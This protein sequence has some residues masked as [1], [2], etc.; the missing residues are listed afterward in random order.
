MLRLMS[1]QLD[2]LR[3][4]NNE[5]IF[6]K[7]NGEKMVMPNLTALLKLYNETSDEA[8]KERAR[9]IFNHEIG[10]LLI[11]EIMIDMQNSTTLNRLETGE[12]SKTM[13]HVG[14]YNIILESHLEK[15]KEQFEALKAQ[16]K[17]EGTFEEVVFATFPYGI[18]IERIK[19]PQFTNTEYVK[20]II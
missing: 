6:E 10:S 19:F 4:V 1:K 16:D 9:E 17:V 12:I 8:I 15:A 18:V 20:E 14:T 11:C 13:R 3:V 2:A 5:V 7:A